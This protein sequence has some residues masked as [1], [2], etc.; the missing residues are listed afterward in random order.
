MV[1]IVKRTSIYI[2]SLPFNGDSGA[3]FP[4]MEDE[5]NNAS[6][7]GLVRFTDEGVCVKH[8]AQCLAPSKPVPSFLCMN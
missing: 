3:W 6:L 8:L 4:H 5:G 7:L 2:L 1:F